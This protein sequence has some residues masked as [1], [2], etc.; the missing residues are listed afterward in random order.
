MKA[1][2]TLAALLLGTAALAHSGVTNPDVMNRMMGMS[3]LAKQMKV[4]G[5][6]AKGQTDFDADAVNAA[7]A[8]MS[9]EA[10]YIPSLFEIEAPDPKS[11]A[12]PGIW[13]N[14]DD[15]K[16]HASTLETVTARLSGTVEG[17]GDL[18][19]A[20]KEVGQVCSACHA[21]YRKK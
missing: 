13:Q 10:S 1:Y 17:P 21:D 16:G 9:E 2:V 3:E 11:E 15:F 12:L 20:M 5:E 14:F 4:L 19:P 6:M 8:K 18:A 7:L